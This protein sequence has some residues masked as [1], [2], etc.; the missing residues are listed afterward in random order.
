MLH[1]MSRYS[2]F[3]PTGNCDMAS[4]AI[5]TTDA[6]Y[7]PKVAGLP[8]IGSAIPFQKAK[9][10]PV[11][12]MQH[13]QRT[14]G[15]V[16]HIQVLN[17]TL[18]LVSHPDLI[19]DILVKRTAEFHKPSVIS[20]KPLAL[21]RFLGHGILTVDHE[22]WKPQ[23]KMIQPLMH[24]K[25]IMGYGETMAKF[26][27]QLL[28][29]WSHDSVRDIHADMTQVTMW[30]IAD[31]MF[32]MTIDQS[33]VMQEV[34]ESAQ[35]LSIA[36][37]V[38]PIPPSIAKWRD[39]QADHINEV[40]SGLVKHFMDERRAQGHVERNDLLSLLMNTRDE[41]G[42][43]MPDEFVRDNI[44]TL[45]FAG[46]ETTANTLTWAFYY[47]A[48]NPAVLQTLHAEVDSVLAGRLPTLEDLHNLPYTMMVI[49][50]TMRVEPTVSAFPRAILED[51]IL[52]G[53][54]LKAHSTVFVP[55]YITHHDPRWWSNPEQF[56]PTRFS[57]ENEPNIPKYA[58]FPFGGGPRICIGNHFALMEAQILLALIASRYT[59][60]LLP[61][62]TVEAVRQITVSPKD[63]LPMRLEK[64]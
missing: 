43:P 39:Y 2:A 9:G 21:S 50:E 58:Y 42:N 23:R 60:H 52:G 30:I 14:Y 28:D 57:V 6:P 37:F 29:S 45:F 53:Y 26:G 63:G 33:P 62:H 20:K 44:L 18:Y 36:D 8:L 3:N 64:R 54:K 17:K 4:Q 40:L 19:H 49:K 55:P 31:T 5:P 47:L 15:D 34:G 35:R 27:E 22:E 25:H 10:L 41:D 24:A 46:H 16:V 48:Q 7:P 12:F 56:D 11:D 38:S 61:N 32:G 59:L 13:A 51:V 1:I